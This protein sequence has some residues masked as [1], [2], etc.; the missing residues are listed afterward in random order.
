LTESTGGNRLG[1]STIRAI[2][3]LAGF[4][5]FLPGIRLFGRSYS[6]TRWPMTP[7]RVT[8]SE[9]AATPSGRLE[10][11]VHYEYI[12][13]GRVRRGRMSVST[14]RREAADSVMARFPAGREIAV[15]YDPGDPEQSTLRP[16]IKWWSLVLTLAGAGLMAG[17]LRPRKP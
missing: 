2:V 9:I 14:P 4:L 1:L 11:S 13:A 3:I 17:G 8:A 16:R 5:A 10:V 7:G 12:L 6:M 15:G